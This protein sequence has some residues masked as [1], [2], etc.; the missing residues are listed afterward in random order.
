MNRHA[1]QL[2]HICDL[3]DGVPFPVAERKRYL[4]RGFTLH[5]PTQMPCL[6]PAI[7]WHPDTFLASKGDVIEVS[8]LRA[9]WPGHGAW[10]RLFQR[11]VMSGLTVV[12]VCPIGRFREHIERSEFFVPTLVDGIPS[13]EFRPQA[14]RPHQGKRSE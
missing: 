8:V 3:I 14:L 5:E 2:A 13:Y 11:L 6:L 12:V 7:E 4:A 10:A 9:W 1:R